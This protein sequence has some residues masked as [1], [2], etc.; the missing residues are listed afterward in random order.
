VVSARNDHIRDRSANRKSSKEAS[1]KGKV[2]AATIPG[3]LGLEIYGSE[4]PS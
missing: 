3:L 1:K 2:T 4:S